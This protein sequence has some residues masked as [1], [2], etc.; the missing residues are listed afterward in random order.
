MPQNSTAN[1]EQ[2]PLYFHSTSK[3]GSC[4]MSISSIDFGA[5]CKP[6]L[7]WSQVASVFET[8]N[9]SQLQIFYHVHKLFLENIINEIPKTV[10]NLLQE[11]GMTFCDLEYL[12]FFSHQETHT[13][14]IIAADWYIVRIYFVMFKTNTSLLTNI[15]SSS[16]PISCLEHLPKMRWNNYE[17][18]SN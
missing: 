16:S 2:L 1:F 6:L 9:K 12:F 10:S 15:P 8:R 7:N 17:T 5:S 18:Y 3:E 13:N 14:P 4:K 11:S